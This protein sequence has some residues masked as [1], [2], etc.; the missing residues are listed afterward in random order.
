MAYQIDLTGSVWNGRRRRKALVRFLLLAA[1]GGAAWGIYDSYG[2][3]KQPTLNM[4]LTDYEAVARP[5]EDV[6]A[7]WDATEKEYGALFCYYRLV[8]AASPTNFLDRM[9]ASDAPGFGRRLQPV[10]WSLKTGGECVLSYRF[11]FD[12]GDKFEQAKGLEDRIVGTVTSVV[13]VVDGRVEVAGVRHEDLL[14]VGGFD[15][16]V[17]F[18]LP[19]ARAFPSKEPSLAGCV[20]EI[21]AFR[22]KVQEEAK[23]KKESDAKGV[24]NTASAVMIA[25]LSKNF[26]KGKPDFPAMK[27][28]IDVSGWLASADRFIARY[29][30]PVDEAEQR[31]LKGLWNAVGEAR[32]PWE[33]FR[34]LDNEDLV[35]RTKALSSVADGVRRFKEFL[36]PRRAFCRKMLDPF[37]ECYDRNRVFNEPVI[38]DDLVVRLAKVAGVSCVQVAF[39][40]EAGAEPAVL[41]MKDE[42]FVFTWVRWTL[43]V[44]GGAGRDGARPEAAEPLPLEKLADY[45]RRLLGYGPGYALDTVKIDLAADGKSVSGA[46]ME[47]LLPVKKVENGGNQNVR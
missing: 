17:R 10:N 12:P 41:D 44:G 22:K 43:T 1:T 31:K 3:Y 11:T 29:R 30:I 35:R 34:Y 24:P 28:V 33:R 37:V 6:N 5:I 47:G 40:D 46:V 15:V 19:D 23:L 18:R 14:D 4:R 26:E 32:L 13:A 39:R 25:Y 9:V 27:N 8:W 2:V 42:R 36:E 16:T 21:E 20:K 45:L 38:S 7:L